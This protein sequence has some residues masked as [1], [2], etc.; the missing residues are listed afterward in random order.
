MRKKIKFLVS[1]L[2]FMLLS[3]GQMVLINYHLAIGIA[4]ILTLFAVLFLVKNDLSSK[5]KKLFIFSI[6]IFS[7]T[8]ICWLFSEQV[9]FWYIS[10]LTLIIIFINLAVYGFFI[11][12][13]KHGSVISII[14]NIIKMLILV[15][16]IVISVL[17]FVFSISSTSFN[18]TLQSV[19]GVE[20][21]TK[22]EQ[23][24]SILDDKYK[25]YSNVKYDSEYPRGFLDVMTKKGNLDP[26]RPTFFY[27][28]GGGFVAGDKMGGDPNSDSNESYLPYHY[29]KMI[30]NG[31][32]V[33]A[34]NYAFAPEY[35]HPTQVKQIS[36]AIQFL[37]KNGYKY[38]IN[39]KD[40]VISGGSAGGQ[41][42]AEFV[43]IQSNEKYAKSINVKPVMNVKNIRAQVLE[44]PSL[45]PSKVHS[46]KEENKMNDYLF[47]QAMGAYIG[48][49]II[50]YN[51]STED[52][53]NLIK[54]V[55][56]DFPPTFITDGN[57][58]SFKVQSKEY[59]DELKKHNVKSELYIPD[60]NKSKEGHGYI[61]NVKSDATIQFI[62]KRNGFL[63]EL[64]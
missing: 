49:P 42:A 23:K 59:Y 1:S 17:L 5:L 8:E 43:T 16:V 36:N 47:G 38:G 58:G 11:I 4:I 10:Q 14:L 61:A 18:K 46:T 40:M 53:M 48:D 37:Q 62:K 15:L 41:I 9:I 51:Q 35:D 52:Q 24:T 31:Y 54:Y 26:N 25:L 39:T 63:Q 22:S 19:M 21:Y 60:I 33:V 6:V 12:S 29:K 56:K 13:R 32:N 45:K 3:W 55:N 44:V 50:S 20:N 2:V 34:V 57:E 30:D 27:I 7:V 28:H 64:N